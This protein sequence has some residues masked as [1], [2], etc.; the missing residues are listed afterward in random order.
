MALA[1]YQKAHRAGKQ[2]FEYRSMRGEQPTLPVLDD[3]LPEGIRC[4]ET[5]L[6]IMNIPLDRIVGTRHE[7]RS[8]SFASNFMPLLD[9]GSEFASKW[10]AVAD[11]HRDT[12]IADPIKAYEYLHNYYVEEGNKR[13]S[14]MKY[15]DAVSIPAKV[16]RVMPPKSD[17][18]EIRA[19][20]EFLKFY[21]RTGI[22]DIV[23]HTEGQYSALLAATGKDPSHT[24]DDDEQKDF[25]SIFTRFK[26]LYAQTGGDPSVPIDEAFLQFLI[27]QN[28][29]E[30]T[31]LPQ[32]RL[33]DLVVRSQSEFRLMAKEHP[34]DL[35]TEPPQKKQ[36]SLFARMF[37]S[38]GMSHVKVAFIYEKTIRS[39]SWTYAHELG[40]LSLMHAY[41]NEIDTEYYENVTEETIDAVL[42]DAIARGNRVIFTTTPVFAQASVRAAIANPQVKIV[43][44]SINTSYRSIRT[45]YPRIHEAKFVLGALAAAMSSNDRLFY[46]GD[47][48]LYGSI[49]SINAFALGAQM[50]NPRAEIY[51]DWTS[52]KDIDVD[53]TIRRAR[54]GCVLGKDM[55]VPNEE[56]RYFG[57]Y[58]L[59][60]KH[61]RR[62]AMP[63]VYWGKLYQKLVEAI[64]DGTWDQE[65]RDTP[66]AAINYWWGMSSDIVGIFYASNLPLGTIRMIRLLMDTI[67]KGEFYPFSGRLYSQDG[68]VTEDPRGRMSPEDVIHMDWLAENVIGEIPSVSKLNP[69]AAPVVLRSGVPEAVSGNA[70]SSDLLPRESAPG[71]DAIPIVQSGRRLDEDLA[72]RDPQTLESSADF[73]TGD[74][75]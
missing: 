67:K 58:S 29:D 17:D 37:S 75:L 63:V 49:A 68:I 32:S 62:L 40:R 70:L 54:P 21:D 71:A 53:E 11:Y 46:L 50:V 16:I 41:P 12:G 23:F 30:L 31:D 4:A 56:A 51:L 15:F 24:W 39:S 33:R 66:E 65:E 61:S 74:V 34:V 47:Y 35:V 57:L 73:K 25:R 60:G 52:R 28:Y 36:Q 59:E 20:Y 26:E 72:S 69:Q 7:E 14:V 3:I 42:K 43:N 18:P 55:I 64:S 19:Y 5:T 1:D 38:S 45:Y 22:A 27:V 44:C 13:V 48:P 9:D 8:Y 6:G 10:A 2:D